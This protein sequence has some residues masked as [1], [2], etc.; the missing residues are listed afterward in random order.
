MAGHY[1]SKLPS[2]DQ[3]FIRSFEVM[4]DVLNVSGCKGP[5]RSGAEITSSRNNC[6]GDSSF[7]VHQRSSGSC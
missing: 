5:G 7:R 2:E 1:D 6:L 4:V 3:Q